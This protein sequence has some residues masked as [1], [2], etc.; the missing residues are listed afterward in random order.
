MIKDFGKNNRHTKSHT[1]EVNLWTIHH[2][3]PV[4]VPVVAVEGDGCDIAWSS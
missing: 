2:L 4:V 3:E 1:Q